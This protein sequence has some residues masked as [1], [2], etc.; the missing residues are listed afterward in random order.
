MSFE[1]VDPKSVAVLGWHDGAEWRTCTWEG[2]DCANYVVEAEDIWRGI[3]AMGLRAFNPERF[4]YKM[5]KLPPL[6][7]VKGTN[8]VTVVA[9][10]K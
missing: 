3:N 4:G 6:L 2:F 9:G 5:Y 1:P 10:K 8:H 7:L